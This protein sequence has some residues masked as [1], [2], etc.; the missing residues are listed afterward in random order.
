MPTKSSIVLNTHLI[1]L[2]KVK[3]WVDQE[4]QRIWATRWYH[5]QLSFSSYRVWWNESNFMNVFLESQEKTCWVKISSWYFN[6]QQH[7]YVLLNMKGKV[8]FSYL[9]HAM[10]TRKMFT[11]TIFFTGFSIIV[12]MFSTFIFLLTC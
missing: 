8:N 6:W 12:P 10:V 1:D 9:M 4:P 7:F 11:S 5:C 2:R 3:G